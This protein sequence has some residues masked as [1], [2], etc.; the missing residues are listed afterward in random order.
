MVGTTGMIS[1][2]EDKES[3]SLLVSTMPPYVLAIDNTSAV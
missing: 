1:G 3:L 2:I